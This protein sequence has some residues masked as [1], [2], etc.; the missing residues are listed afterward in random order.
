MDMM[1]GVGT[2]RRGALLTRDARPT[3][4]KAQLAALAS[5]EETLRALET[6]LAD[7]QPSECNA[8]TARQEF[9]CREYL[10][11]LNASAAARRAGYS[12]KWAGRQAQENLQ[13]PLIQTR[14]QHLMAERVERV[15]VKADQVVEELAKIAFSDIRDVVKWDGSRAMLTPS[16]EVSVSAAG[17]IKTLRVRGDAQEGGEVVLHDKLKALELLR[18]H[19]GMDARP[20]EPPQVVLVVPEKLT[21]EEWMNRYGGLNDSLEPPLLAHEIAG[22]RGT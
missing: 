13:K 15:R 10:I 22:Q 12:T 7:P 18:K 8:L 5:R 3:S 1:S 16:D 19:L 14:I 21:T 6:I 11:D 2:D 9:F 17:A 20:S 4:S